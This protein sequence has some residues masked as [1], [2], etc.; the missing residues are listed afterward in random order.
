[1]IIITA[2]A[3]T[4][5]SIITAR[6]GIT[7]QKKTTIIATV[8]ICKRRSGVSNDNINLLIQLSGEEDPLNFNFEEATLRQVSTPLKNNTVKEDT[9]VIYDDTLYTLGAE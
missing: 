5:T 7:I 4:T 9:T 8:G 3:G 6:A 1:M 2:R